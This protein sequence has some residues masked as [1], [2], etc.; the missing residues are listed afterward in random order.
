MT[1]W[2]LILFLK[3]GYA[4]GVVA[5]DMPSEAACKTALVDVQ[6]MASQRDSACVQRGPSP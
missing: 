6:K 2:L 3:W 5:I 4:G 1:P